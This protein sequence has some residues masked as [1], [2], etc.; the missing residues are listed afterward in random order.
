HYGRVYDLDVA[1]DQVVTGPGSKSL[2]FATLQSLGE[3]IIIPRPSWVTY[4][5]QVHLIGKPITWVPTYPENRYLVGTEELRAALQASHHDLGNPE[6]LILNNP[7]N[8]TGTMRSA[9]QNQALAEFCREHELMVVS[10]EI[11][12]RTAFSDIPFVSFGKYY[13]EGTVIMGGLS[14]DLSLGGWRIGASVV[15]PTKGGKALATALTSIATNVWSCVAAPVQYAALVAYS[16]DPEIDAYVDLCAK[17]HAIRTRYLYDLMVRLGVQCVEPSGAFYVFPCF[18]EWREPLNDRGI[19]NDE[20]LA[21]HLLEKYEIAA[22]PGSAFNSVRDFCLRVSSSFIDLADDDQADRL[23]AAFRNDPDPER[24]I[25]DF[26]PRLQ[27]AA[28]RFGDF[29]EELRK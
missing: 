22:L 25:R 7:D 11:Y 24:F 4:A 3:E 19:N 5:P 16:G 15:P 28:E 13:R 18:D 1:P 12:A 14:K 17:M 23:V 2:I 27:R 10:D 9:E 29:I 6:V 8:P 20:E 26:H 21:T